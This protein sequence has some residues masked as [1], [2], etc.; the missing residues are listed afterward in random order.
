MGASIINKGTSATS[1]PTLNNDSQIFLKTI[2]ERAPQIF[3]TKGLTELP[4]SEGRESFAKLLAPPANSSLPVLNIKTSNKTL[5]IEEHVH[6]PVRVYTPANT[7]GGLPVIVYF[8][9][10]GFVFG[11]LNFLDYTCGALAEKSQCIV[12]SVAYRLAPEHKFPAAHDDAWLAT[13]YVWEHPKDF[14]G[15]GVVAVAGDSA[16]GNLAASVCHKA[17]ANPAVKIAFQLLFYPWVD[18]NNTTA[19]DQKFG[20]GYFLELTTLTWMREQYLGTDAA[21]TDPVANPQLQ[22]DF[23]GLPPALVVIGECDPIHDDAKLYYEKLVKAGVPAQFIEFGGILH[24][25]CAL[26]AYYEAAFDALGAA[27][28][29][30]KKFVK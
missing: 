8:H 15:N 16:G 28:S 20:K 4:P 12:V 30:L 29:E 21:T 18:M 11:D 25:F 1:V 2:G 17:K 19:S 5:Q 23:T 9:G 3:K 27:S 10:G 7:S 22:T 13:K 26:P 14:G 6:I 24:D